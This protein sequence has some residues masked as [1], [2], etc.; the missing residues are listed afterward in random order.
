MKKYLLIITLAIFSQSGLKAQLLV[1]GDH[2][3]PVSGTVGA[4]CF[5]PGNRFVAC[6]LENGAIHIWDLDAKR[7]LHKLNHGGRVKALLIDTKSRY[8]ISAGTDKNVIIWDL[9]SGE[10]E[11][12]ISAYK[13]KISN[14]NF[15]SDET[16]LSVCGSRKE[17]FLFQFP[18]GNLVAELK[19]GH[20]K[21]VIYSTFNSDG[22]QLLTVARD[23]Q[24]I[25]WDTSTRQILRK[26]DISPNT[27]NGSGIEINSVQAQPDKRR[28]LVA[29]TETKLA[30]GGKS[31]IFKY[32][33]ALYNWDTGLLEN[34][35]EGNVKSIESLDIT[36][37][38]LYY[39]TDNSTLRLKK[40]NFWDINTGNLVKSQQIE[41]DVESLKISD[42]GEWLAL[43]E[44]KG[45]KKEPE[46]KLYK[47]SGLSAVSETNKNSNSLG[48]RPSFN[49][50]NTIQE[51]TAND[52]LKTDMIGKYYALL[53]GINEYDDPMITDLDAPITD[54]ENFYTILSTSYS[55]R[56][57][58]I[59]F[60]EN[61]KRH[62]II[63][64][65]DLL[66]RTVTENDNL[67]IFYAGHGHWDANA[68]KGYWLPSDAHHESTANWFRNSS[69]TGYIASIK[70]KHTLLI[71]DACFS[72]SIFKTRAAFPKDQEAVARLYE[73]P[74]RKAMT[75]GTLKEV[76]DQSV[77][78]RFL[79]KN[80]ANNEEEF[81]PSEQLFYTLKPAVLNNSDN[82][83]QFGEVKNAGDEGGDFIF[84]RRK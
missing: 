47:L 36:P 66:E 53:I 43:A 9:Y 23:N 25:L 52:E 37:D 76:P 12:T 29:Y 65:L 46:V 64:A 22:S 42:N 68:H 49:S 59:I 3:I 51:T 7:Q 17:V 55:F 11:K 44:G 16:L 84:I 34:I 69:L 56:K 77:F 71:A 79:M 54:A 75:S 38:G 15:N 67:L 18:E 28:F 1:Y 13:G 83:P 60:L 30:K 81:M 62:E 82:I 8:L 35:Y 50:T 48:T 14:L 32:N 24:V 45:S 63:D 31:M 72:G 73:K 74:S 20:N 10:K 6:G 26:T 57:D 61:P 21:E 27:I 5:S 33:T 40:L 41:D 70:S 19:N 2:N 58:D 80:L 39:I 4:I 78:V